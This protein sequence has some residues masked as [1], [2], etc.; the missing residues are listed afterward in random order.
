MSITIKQTEHGSR[1]KDVEFIWARNSKEFLFANSVL[2]HGDQSVIVDP[3]ASFTYIS[4]LSD[5][6]CIKTVLNTHYHG[7]H[8]SLNHL[9]NNVHFASHEADAQAIS[10]FDYYASIA[11]R[12]DKSFY[13]EWIRN[14]FKKYKIVDCP[15][16]IKLKDGDVLETGAE[17][18][19]IISIPG[20][21]PGHIA[22]YFENADT[23]FVS[24]I[25]LTP[26][27]PWYANTVSDIELFKESIRK[28]RS[29]ECQYYVPSH[30]ER[31]YERDKFL[32][33]LDRFYACFEKRETIIL[34]LLKEKPMEMAELCSHG[35]VYRKGSLG[36][37]L[38]CYFQFEMVG[39]HIEI[40][41][42]EGVVQRDGELLVLR[43]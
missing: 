14:V 11:V 36:D 15:V 2:V 13:L 21:T 27:G 19:R 5:S 24:D 37:L 16:S 38:K 3:S 6:R 23:L 34:D 9:F 30:G 43:K 22:L 10:D 25:D 26:F 20:H 29:F 32:E 7:D 18:I 17:R 31:I 33:K 40:F 41:E 1:I 4:Q 35:I 8:R 42:R 28:I 12:D 39:K